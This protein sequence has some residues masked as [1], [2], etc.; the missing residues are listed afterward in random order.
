M[1]RNEKLMAHSNPAKIK[2]NNPLPLILRRRHDTRCNCARKTLKVIIFKVHR[3]S[4]T[5]EKVLWRFFA[6]L[7][8]LFLNSF[9]SS[10]R[11]SLRFP[12]NEAAQSH[13][14]ARQKMDE[15]VFLH[16]LPKE[17]IS[18][19]TRHLSFPYSFSQH[20]YLNILLVVLHRALSCFSFFHNKNIFFLCSAVVVAIDV[21]ILAAVS[22]YGLRDKLNNCFFIDAQDYFI[23]SRFQ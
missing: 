7:L 12:I 9:V 19:M 3:S 18:F 20:S 5:N 16:V 15:N 17:G 23:R 13:S 2:T 4:G 8:S 11:F 21:V 22:G 10:A 14:K 1:C 6:F